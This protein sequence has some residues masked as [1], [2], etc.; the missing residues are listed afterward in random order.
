MDWVK[1]KSEHVSPS[2]SD[3]QVGA[4][5]RFQLLTARLKRMPNDKEISKEAS[6]KN[7]KSLVKELLINDVT[8]EDIALKVLEDVDSIS[9]KRTK[10]REKKRLQRESIEPLNIEEVS[11]ELDR[12]GV[13]LDGVDTELCHSWYGVDPELD[14]VGAKLDGVDTEL[15]HSWYG[16]DPELDGVGV[17]LDGVDTE[18]CHSWYGVD[19]EKGS[20][21][22]VKRKNVPGDRCLLDKIREDKRR[23]DK[24]RKENKEKE[25]GKKEKEKEKPV[26][27]GA[28]PPPSSDL[29]PENSVQKIKEGWNRFAEQNRLGTI[30]KLNAHRKKAIK[31]RLGEPEFDIGEVF[32]KIEKSAFLLGENDRG[33]KADF[34]F[35]FCSSKNWLKIVEGKYQAASN[36][37]KN[38]SMEEMWNELG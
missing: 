35:V 20:N 6:I 19:R 12:V 24:I 2:L 8:P 11:P 36:R 16:V 34:D 23:E 22:S 7:W 32:S 27:K 18:L 31:A 25:K 29:I 21:L 4:L 30:R 10:E 13:E 3:A 9:A 14:G 15:C 5:V 37:K 33:W 1:I 28:D 17:E 26:G 38:M